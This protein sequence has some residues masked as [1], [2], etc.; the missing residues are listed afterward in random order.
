MPIRA[1]LIKPPKRGSH[2]RSVAVNFEPLGLLY[3][4]AFVKKFSAHQ[5]QVLDAQSQDASLEEL[6]PH[7]FRMGMSDV[8]L[9]RRV[10]D[11]APDVVGISALFEMQERE[12]VEV[13]RLVKEVSPA[14]LVVVGGLD[15]GIRHAS[16]L[17][18][19]VID[20]VVRGD[21]EETFL[22]L[23]DH[24]ERGASL[25]DIPGTCVRDANGKARMNA[26]R[27]PRVP[28]DAHPY[29]DRD[30]LPRALYDG[31]RAQRASFPFSRGRPAVLIQGS[32]GCKLRCAFCDIVAVQDQLVAHSPEYVVDEIQHV[33]ERYG[34]REVVFVDDNF[35]LDQRWARR[36]FELVA[37]RGL[38]VSLDV[39]AGVSV[40][41]LSKSMIDAM[42]RAGVYRV[43]L[44]V[45][46]GNPSTIAFIKKPVN[47]AKAVE[48]IDYCNRSGLYTFA[49]LIVGFPDETRADIQRT[50]DWGHASGLDA[51]HY[52]IATPL[53][54]SRMYPIYEQHGWIEHGARGA[55]TWRTAHFTRDELEAI[56]RDASRAQ[57]RQRVR[58]LARPRNVARYVWPKLRSPRHLRYA[59]RLV[60]QVV[61]SA[62]ASLRGAP[63]AVPSATSR[64]DRVRAAD[65]S[66][67]RAA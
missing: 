5:V 21:G 53:P 16:Y 24:V 49:N 33:V 23:L 56:A 32:R 48:M 62:V 61:A 18:S 44:P 27:V 22:D 12:V 13:A 15:A 38:D 60:A 8:A 51:V 39:M 36:V 6:A 42:I 35:M 41:T 65:P 55:V 57:M 50:V 9:R 59:L 52:F 40:W 25:D 31:R 19:G 30:A 2:P 10:R 26:V 54:G 58:F 14:A 7:D 64:D 63:G 34:A 46:S 37:E 1:L 3:V 29:P 20:V 66:A 4:S 45:E 11:L 43:C 67:A 47:L 28:F 17:A